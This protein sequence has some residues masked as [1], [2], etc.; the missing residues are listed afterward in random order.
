MCCDS[1]IFTF[2][3]STRALLHS[4]PLLFAVL[5]LSH[6]LFYILSVQ[7][8]SVVVFDVNNVYHLFFHFCTFHINKMVKWIKGKNSDTYPLEYF[9]IL[10]L[11]LLLFFGQKLSWMN[12]MCFLL[13]FK[14][15]ALVFLFLAAVI[16]SFCFFLSLSR[17]SIGFQ[18][19]HILWTFEI[20]E[21]LRIH[22]IRWYL[23]LRKLCIHTLH[24]IAICL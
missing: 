3:I 5:L 4:K 23:V 12:S 11:L 13:L 1:N 15:Y 8:V 24:C 20:V 7:V 18:F 19:S 16:C 10:M 17:D 6:S 21:I 14:L 9:G 22:T 2:N